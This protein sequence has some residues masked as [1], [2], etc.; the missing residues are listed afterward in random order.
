M[1]KVSKKCPEHSHPSGVGEI[2]NIC[3]VDHSKIQGAHHQLLLSHE[4]FI[5]KGLHVVDQTQG[6]WARTVEAMG[7]DPV[8]EVQVGRMVGIIPQVKGDHIA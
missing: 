3:S 1:R 7:W 2:S 5:F 4:S 8:K 6:H